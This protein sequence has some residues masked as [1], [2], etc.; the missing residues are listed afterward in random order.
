MEAVLRFLVLLPV[1]SAVACSGMVD[2]P[3]TTK[4]R[5]DAPGP[6]CKPVTEPHWIE[7]G[8]E[9][10]VKL[11]CQTGAVVPGRGFAIGGLPGGAAYDAT[12]GELRWTPGLDQAGVYELQ[13]TVNNGETATLKIGVADKFYDAD[14]VPIVD[15]TTYTEEMGLPVFHLNVDPQ[16]NEADY[17]PASIVYR[18]H[19]YNN[20]GAKYRGHSSLAYPKKNFT[21]KFSKDDR[22]SE[23]LLGGGLM[24]RRRIALTTTFDDNSHIRHRLSYEVWNRLG[25]LRVQNY[26]GVVYLNGVYH[27]IYAITDH[28][29]G[30]FMV[31]RGQPAGGNLFKAMEHDA[32]FWPKD[33]HTEGFVKKEGMPLSGEPG[34]FDDL[35]ALAD[36]V[37]NAPE[38]KFRAELGDRVDLGDY[39]AWLFLTS[40]IQASDSYGKNAFHYHNPDDGIWRVVPW[41]FNASFGQY[42]NTMREAPTADPMEIPSAFNRF[43]QRLLKDEVIGPQTVASFSAALAKQIPVDTV[44]GLLDELAAQVAPAVRRDEIKWRS[45]YITFDRWAARDDFTDFQG[46]LGY[47]RSWIKQRW[48]LVVDKLKNPVAPLSPVIAAM[49]EPP[50]PP[51]K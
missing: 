48:E 8:D 17:V 49:P 51:D 32:S 7:E 36:F 22:F 1:L 50:P 44:L 26:S 2:G 31:D 25:R 5:A 45:T 43:Y 37:A 40:T 20:G 39:R 11:V 34:A 14:N 9:L 6:R 23:P 15:Q 18:G 41:D 10:V 12:T 30:D 16:V 24:N 28:I 29:D 46:E 42:W 35:V 13:V 21:V 38:D 4:P 27:G 3:A 33:D 47:L 19:V